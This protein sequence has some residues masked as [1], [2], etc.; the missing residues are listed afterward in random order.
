MRHLKAQQPLRIVGKFI[1]SAKRGMDSYA[2]NNIAPSGMLLSDTI[3][4]ILF[5]ATA[6]QTDTTA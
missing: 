2:L 6:L 4:F 3:G 5:R 1:D